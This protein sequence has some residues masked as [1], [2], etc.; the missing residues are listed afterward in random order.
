MSDDISKHGETLTARETTVGSGSNKRATSRPRIEGFESR[1]EHTSA[2]EDL[3]L[4]KTTG[5][6]VTHRE[7]RSRAVKK[8]KPFGVITTYKRHF[9]FTIFSS[10]NGSDL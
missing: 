7:S 4:E 10:S 3:K 2:I 8:E 9:I 5:N 6:I 1:S